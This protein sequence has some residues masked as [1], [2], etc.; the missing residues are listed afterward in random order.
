MAVSKVGM[1]ADLTA[2]MKVCMK[3]DMTAGRS[4]V[5]TVQ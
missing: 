5:P 3:A 4:V 1:W 2:E